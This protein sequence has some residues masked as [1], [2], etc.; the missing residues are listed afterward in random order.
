MMLDDTNSSQADKKYK[1]L[2]T[3]KDYKIYFDEQVLNI[4]KKGLDNFVDALLDTYEDGVNPLLIL[5]EFWKK[6]PFLFDKN[7]VWWL[8]N[9]NTCGWETTDQTELINAFNY[10]GKKRFSTNSRH[11]N[12]IIEGMR[13]VGR[14]KIPPEAPKSW[15]QFK[16][17]IFNIATGTIMS[18]TPDYFICN[19]IPYSIGE[20]ETTP[21]MDSL[22]ESWVGKKYVID[23]YEIIA[24]CCYTDYPIHVL[25][26]MIGSGRNGKS[27]FQALLGKFIGS[28]NISS[29]DLDNLLD[30]RFETFKL[31]RKLV[32]NLSEMHWSTITK[33]PKLKRLTG[34]D[35]IGYEKKGCD[36][37]DSYNYAKILISSNALPSSTD[38]S[39]AWFRR[40]MII[41]FPNEF[42]EG[43]DVLDSIPEIEY[44]N[45]ARKC[46]RILPELLGRG[47]FANQGT[48]EERKARYIMA[49]NPLP[50]FLQHFCTFDVTGYVR[51]SELYNAYVKFLTKNKRR[52]VTTKE[53]NQILLTEG[54]EVRRTYKNNERDEWIECLTLN[55]NWDNLIINSMSLSKLSNLSNRNDIDSICNKQLKNAGYFGYSGYSDFEQKYI[56]EYDL[57]NLVYHKCIVSPSSN[58]DIGICNA[59]PCN[60]NDNGQPICGKHWHLFYDF[61]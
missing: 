7:K 42:P 60:L 12:E 39:E 23:L 5:D 38:D 24:Y 13:Q 27:R 44:N 46:V 20:D 41:E 45:L 14:R 52:V 43:K 55:S 18:A 54:Y 49:S 35:L 34:Q 48:I 58:Y 3:D 19:P 4:Q 30:N 21:I 40:W 50:F 32:C 56:P 15:V 51:K 36:P 10:K 16:D 9:H 25:I 11:K 26:A 28:H 37:F 53:F 6:R 1:E 33:S 61:K 47:H 57:N 8:W 22:F 29:S 2:I 17:K 31:Y 59:S